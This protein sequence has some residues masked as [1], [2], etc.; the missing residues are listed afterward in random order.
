MS[1]PVA[2]VSRPTVVS[3]DDEEE[4]MSL[5]GWQVIRNGTQQPIEAAL[6]LP[7]ALA[8]SA[9]P[10]LLAAAVVAASGAVAGAL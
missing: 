10:V 4:P 1:S 6:V 7:E 8:L 2:K 3:P 5:R 9:A